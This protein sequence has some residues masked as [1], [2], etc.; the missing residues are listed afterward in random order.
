M[1]LTTHQ[2]LQVQEPSS[3]VLLGR[4]CKGVL[5]AVVVETALPWR[6]RLRRSSRPWYVV[7]ACRERCGS[8]GGR[9][10]GGAP[11]PPLIPPSTTSRGGSMSAGARGGGGG[12]GSAGRFTVPLQRPAVRASLFLDRG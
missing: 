12:G 10:P 8:G 11:G 7:K 6:Q 2:K 5:V 3:P 9:W 4:E 1:P